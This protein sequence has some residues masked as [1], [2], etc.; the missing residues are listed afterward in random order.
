MLFT[1]RL[2]SQKG[3][4]PTTLGLKRYSSSHFLNP[5]VFTDFSLFNLEGCHVVCLLFHPFCFAFAI[6]CFWLCV[7]SILS[8]QLTFCLYI[9]DECP[10]GDDPLV[11]CV[12]DKCENITTRRSCCK[13]C[14]NANTSGVDDLLPASSFKLN[15]SSP[16]TKLPIGTNPNTV[17]KEL[18]STADTDSR[19]VG[20]VASSNRPTGI[21]SDSS[22]LQPARNT[23]SR[24]TRIIARPRVSHIG[25]NLWN[26]GSNHHWRPRTAFWNWIPTWRHNVLFGK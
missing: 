24:Q 22:N 2:R 21:V 4:P 12:V 25:S 7:K 6:H 3:L 17:I 10:F 8:L 1:P 5:S 26:A 19:R 11:N 23:A 13:T 18:P 14:S 15:T 16:R 20:R 9:T